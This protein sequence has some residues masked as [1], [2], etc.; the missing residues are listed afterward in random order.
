VDLHCPFCGIR[1]ASEFSFRSLVPDRRER[2]AHAL[3]YER[4]NDP[5]YSYEY[6]QHVHGCRAWLL[7]TR[8]PS[9]G[10]VYNVRL[11]AHDA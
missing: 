11:L 3:V 2:S 7:I 1:D 4:V 6:W 8:N 5:N 9:N 10:H